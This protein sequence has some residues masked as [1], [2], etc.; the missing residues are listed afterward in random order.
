MAKLTC[1]DGVNCIGGNKLLLESNSEK[2]FFDFGQNM[3]EEGRFYEEFIKPKTV[4]GIYERAQLGFL[5]P[6]PD[7]YRPDLVSS[8]CDPWV[9]IETSSIGDVAGVLVSHAHVDHIGS[10]PFL[11]TDIPVMCSPMTAAITKALQDT[12]KDG[13]EYCHYVE[14]TDDGE[15]G[16]SKPGYSKNPL[17]SRP[18]CLSE[19][20]GE[21]L[22]DFWNTP[23]ASRQINPSQL[24]CGTKCG[25]MPVRAFPVDHSIYGATAWAVE[26]DAGWV[27]YTGDLRMH[28]V[29]GDLT[30]Q[31]AI[32]ASKLNPV[33]LIIEGTRITNDSQFTEDDVREA[34]LAEVR[35]ASALVV[36][37][38]GARNLE[39]LLTFLDVAREVGRK[40]VMM[41]SDLYM[42][43]AMALASG[44]QKI[45]EMD[46]DWVSI[47]RKYAGTEPKWS[48]NLIEEH[49]SML[50][51]ARDIHANQS[52]FICC[53]GFFDINE[54]AYV[55][56]EPG[57]IWIVSNCEP[58]C[59]EMEIDR[60]RMM[61]W[62][63]RYQMRLVG[64]EEEVRFHVSGHASR[65]DLKEI[66][67]TIRPKTLI[68]VHNE[69]PEEYL[70]MVG[71]LCK[72]VMPQRSV[73]IPIGG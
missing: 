58:F 67:E 6:L 33:A 63:D 61:N 27:V 48:K 12:G 17:N 35:G 45:P 4:A 38:F 15:G 69:H 64:S 51:D 52:S 62:L 42:L 65:S 1:Y 70:D 56:P 18:Y 21:G 57:S 23:P 43:K 34:V 59:E 47:Y 39:R 14:R 2:L 32:E 25:D 11:R 55:R 68:P 71:D 19:S 28:G 53:F 24:T 26:T 20:P 5:P 22:C 44:K 49:S 29:S 72:V 30:R 31:F 50:V 7:L 3:G 66:V 13:S 36:A 16:L 40:L 10:L 41:P 60:R 54:L 73:P 37:D 46:R 9:S 8:L